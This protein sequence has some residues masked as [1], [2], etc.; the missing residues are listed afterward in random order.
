MFNSTHT[1]VGFA[2]ARTGLDEWVPYAAATSV[3][4]ANLPDIEILSGLSSTA[5]YL[6]N[7]RGI[8]HTFVGIPVLALALAGA[9]YYFSENFWKTFTVALLSM[10]THPVLD[11]TNNYGLRPFLPFSGTWYYGDLLFIFDPYIDGILLLGLIAGRYLNGRRRNMAFLSLVLVITYVGMRVE[12]RRLAASQM[13]EFAAR[14]PSAEQWAVLPT[15]ANPFVWDG[16]VKTRTQWLMVRIHATK[17]GQGDI[18]RIERGAFSDA[19]KHAAQAE[20]A[21]ALLRFARF[22]AVRVE[23]VESGY[24][25]L[26]MDFRFYNEARKT[27]LGAEVLLD[28]SFQV[29]KE[30]LSFAQSVKPARAAS[31]GGRQGDGVSYSH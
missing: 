29:R 13:A 7:H 28:Q 21:A 14:T 17:G 11:Y 25:V 5:A 12:L 3:I 4:A 6:D 22:P 16:F 19:V 23:G 27:S 30:T 31:T 26:F 15:M 8:S 20:T 9:M 24:R 10:A 18:A 2:L 1:L